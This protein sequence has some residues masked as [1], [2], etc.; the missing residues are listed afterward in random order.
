M[1]TDGSKEGG[2]PLLTI[3]PLEVVPLQGSRLGTGGD[4]DTA[5]L[6]LRSPGAEVPDREDEVP[7]PLFVWS[8]RTGGGGVL[9]SSSSVS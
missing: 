6:L 9:L 3:S 8:I 1:T 5:P 4:I 7:A 2:P